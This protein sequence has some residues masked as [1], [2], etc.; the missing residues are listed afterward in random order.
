MRFLTNNY[1][2]LQGLRLTPVWLFLAF[3]PWF[4]PLPNHRPIYFRDWLILAILLFCGVWIWFAGRLYHRRYGRV[5]SKPT[6]WWQT[7]CLAAAV[8]VYFVCYQA[9]YKHS[10]VSFTAMW[11][12]CFL[13]GRAVWQSGGEL[14]RTAYAF[15]GVCMLLVAFVPLTGR[16]PSSELLNANH[17]SGAI[18]LGAVMATLGILDH[19]ELVR[20]IS[21][22]SRSAHA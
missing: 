3:R 6:P 2:N 8:A 13:A 10:L 15:A 17:P 14:R 21:T 5:Q 19:L 9:D 18:V 7:L 20:L 1:F 16:I 12:S 11:W 4:Q 22:Q